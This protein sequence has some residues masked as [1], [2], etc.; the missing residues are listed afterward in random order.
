MLVYPVGESGEVIQL[1]LGVLDHFDRHRQLRFWHREAGGQLFARIDGHRIVVCEATGPKPEDKR[2]RTFFEPDRRSE[3]AEIDTLFARD[4]HYVGDWHTHPEGSPTPSARDHV[5]MASR[6]RLSRH[7][8]A[9][10]L[11]VIVGQLPP[12]KG[13][14]VVI[15]DGTSGHVLTPAN[16]D[17]VADTA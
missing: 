9:G 4:L 5:T 11:F 16:I 10:F 17:S 12:P 15:H 2:G 8:L 6:V 14:T 3:Q 13:L 1:E 7:R